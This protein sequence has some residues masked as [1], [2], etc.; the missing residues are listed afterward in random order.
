MARVLDLVTSTAA[1][2]ARAGVGDKIGALGPRPT[3]P[4]LLWDFEACP[5]CRKV[6]EA[7]SILDLEVMVYPCPKGGE[8]FRPDVIARGGKAQFPFLVD[9]DDA[10]RALYES[11]AIIAHL[12]ARY[13]AGRPPLALRMGPITTATAGLASALRP[14]G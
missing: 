2:V 5:F 9:P 7:I 13:G 10:D 4:L 14:R 1:S 6:R 12:F 11:D 3:Q 8:R